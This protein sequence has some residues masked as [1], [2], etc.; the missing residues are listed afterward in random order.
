MAAQ[1][2]GRLRERGRLRC[3]ST[4]L[5]TDFAVHHLWLHSGNDRC[6][7]PNGDVVGEIA[8]RTRRSALRCAPVVRPEFTRTPAGRSGMDSG[9]RFVL[10]SGGAWGV[11]D[12]VATARALVGSGRYTPL[13][14]CGNNARLRRRL[15]SDGLGR[16]LGWR[17][18]VPELMADAYALVDN[19]SGVTCWEAFSAGLPVVIHRPIPGHGVASAR[20]MAEASVVSH[21]GT[22]SGLL[23]ALD[24]LEDEAARRRRTDRAF[25]LFS[26]LPVQAG[27]ISAP[28]RSR[29]GSG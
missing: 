13:V 23:D 20:A 3:P 15:E 17:D 10:V 22:A 28:G 24:L 12:I 19:G 1:I 2:T 9:G 6:L 7:S 26:A 27:L 16:A 18:D 14:L 11:G 29:H 8:V 25:A 21:T 5:V 4:V